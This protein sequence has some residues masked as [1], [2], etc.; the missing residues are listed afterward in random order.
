MSRVEFYSF[1]PQNPPLARS[2]L[3]GLRTSFSQSLFAPKKVPSP[4]AHSRL[5][6]LLRARKVS[7]LNLRFKSAQFPRKLDFTSFR[8]SVN[9]HLA[10]SRLTGLR[11]FFSQA[12]LVPKKVPPPS[13][14]S[15][16]LDL[17]RARVVSPTSYRSVGSTRSQ[18][19]LSSVRKSATSSRS[20]RSLDR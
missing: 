12:L 5:L 1:P 4:S 10:R 11:T 3:T 16:F 8:P 7:L 14:H 9:P 15:R 20:S 18:S 17:L 19:G 2:R 6:D 13:A